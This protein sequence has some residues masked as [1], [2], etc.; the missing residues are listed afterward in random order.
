M[1]DFAAREYSGQK[2]EFMEKKIKR[3]NLSDT[4]SG[5]IRRIVKDLYYISETD[6]EIEP[7]VGKNAESA[8]KESLLS[9]TGAAA[10][11]KVEELNF[12]DFFL[13][14]TEIQDWFGDEE[15]KSAAKFSQLKEL[16]QKELKDL[17]I[18]KVGQIELDIYAV[19]LDS[20]SVL[21][22]IKTKS[23]ET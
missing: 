15:K 20:N 18:F 13:R 17:K 7:F 23:V 11:S 3:K 10:D 19:G 22:G 16:L 2:S 4:L 1:L 9:Q 14:L 21:T 6:A 8:N 5:R 12:D